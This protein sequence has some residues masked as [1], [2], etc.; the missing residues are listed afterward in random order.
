MNVSVNPAALQPTPPAIAVRRTVFSVLLAISVSHF[1]NDL[2]QLLLP[3]IYPLLKANYA[4]SFTEIG[5][6]T[7][8]FQ[9]TA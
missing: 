3:A 2:M 5:L 7:L 9:I 4:L 8:T 6:L 1:L